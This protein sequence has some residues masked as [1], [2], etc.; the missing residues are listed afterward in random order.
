MDKKHRGHAGERYGHLTTIKDTGKRHQL[1]AVW[2]FRCDCGRIVERDISHV[3]RQVKRGR[4]PS[5]GC[6]FTF[7]RSKAHGGRPKQT[8]SMYDIYQAVKEE[9]K[10][11]RIEMS[12]IW[13]RG[14]EFFYED[15]VQGW[16]KGATVERIDPTKPYCK[17]NCY[18]KPKKE[19]TN[20]KQRR[21]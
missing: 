21:P 7:Y 10:R 19:E 8:P 3:R 14:F 11:G 13:F 1:N 9:V 12:P 16:T 4:S 15:M 2:E 18:W 20:G 6:M 17:E 5:C